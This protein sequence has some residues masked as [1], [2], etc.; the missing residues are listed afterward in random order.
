MKTITFLG[1]LI[2]LILASP[3]RAETE[4]MVVGD[5]TFDLERSISMGGEAVSAMKALTHMKTPVALAAQ[6]ETSRAEYVKPCFSKDC[7]GIISG[8]AEQCF[9]KGCADRKSVV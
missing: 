6:A 2:T 3:V 4:K 9:S 5:S 8:D 1:I 7:A